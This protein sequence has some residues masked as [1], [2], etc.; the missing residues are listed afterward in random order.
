M[1]NIPMTEDGPDMDM[2]E[3]LVSKDRGNQGYLVCTEVF[4]SYGY[5]IF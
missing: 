5:N 3:G 1:I 2:V 4:K